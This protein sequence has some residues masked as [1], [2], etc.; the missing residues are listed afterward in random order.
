MFG[1]KKSTR[2]KF[3]CSPKDVCRI[4]DG[5]T[6]A[7]LRE[8]RVVEKFL[9]DIEPR[10]NSA[11]DAFRNGRTDP[12]SVYVIA[13][14]VAYVA[15][16]SPTAMRVHSDPL[17]H[18]V[19]AT[20]KV[21]DTQGKFRE[22]PDIFGARTITELIEN[23]TLEVSINQKYPQ[24]IGIANIFRFASALGNGVWDIVVNEHVRESPFFTS[25]FPA[26]I[27]DN[28]NP[29]LKNRVV[30]LA[31]D[32]AVRITALPSRDNGI[33]MNFPR[34]RGR[35]V[36]PRAFDIRCINETIVRNAEELIFYRDEFPWLTRFVEK[37]SRFRL[38]PLTE[39][40]TLDGGGSLI[41]ATQR[42]RQRAAV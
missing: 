18:T 36:R 12:D 23:N 39:T 15:T 2:E 40:I 27:E 4:E 19:E 5:S 7:Y 17:K 34:F 32:L 28:A 25:D 41:V 29:N 6:N 33:D 21:L 22:P 11:I 31:P 10:Y 20:T 24:A 3:P 37:N 13:G 1:I 35:F 30:P 42:V 14:F 9:R 38:E 8:E 26:A 16:C